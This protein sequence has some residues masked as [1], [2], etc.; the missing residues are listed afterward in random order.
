MLSAMSEGKESTNK[1]K[2]ICRFRP[3]NEAE[4]RKQRGI[5]K[6]SFDIIDKAV[7]RRREQD[8]NIFSNGETKSGVGNMDGKLLGEPYLFDDIIDENASQ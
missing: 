7:Y 1:V 6:S 5:P 8:I 2:A 3:F 4:F